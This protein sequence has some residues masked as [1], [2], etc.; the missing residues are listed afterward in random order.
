MNPF[1][2][3]VIEYG[4]GEIEVRKY[5]SCLGS[6]PDHDEL[7]TIF[8]DW[9]NNDCK[10]VINPFTGNEEVLYPWYSSQ[11]AE[12]RKKHS[13]RVSYNRTRNEVYKYSRMVDWQVMITLTFS[14]EYVNR[15]DFK[16]CMSKARNWFHN[17][18]KRYSNE[19]TYLVVPE[20]HKDGAWHIHGL[21]ANLGDIS[22]SYSGIK[23]KSGRKIYNLDGW[24]FGFSTC[25]FVDNTHKV[26]GYICKYI[27]KDLCRITKGSHRYYRSKNIA[28]PIETMGLLEG[29]VDINKYLQEL[30]DLYC[31][32][33]SYGKRVTGSFVDTDYFYL[34]RKENLL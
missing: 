9:D 18:R 24:K 1:N 5:S 3:K 7:T 33:Y 13:E 17:Q 19:F 32:E 2:F 10:I 29:S 6:V 21:C 34:M 23:D 31:A 27:T 30:C 16:L 20:Q 26:S 8:E 22:Y 15:Y 14:S 12:F 4:N 11:D 28:E 25:V